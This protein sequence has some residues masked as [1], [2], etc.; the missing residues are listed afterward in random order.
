MHAAPALV[1]AAEQ[2]SSDRQANDHASQLPDQRL[3]HRLQQLESDMTKVRLCSSLQDISQMHCSSVTV[4][5]VQVQNML[6]LHSERLDHMGTDQRSCQQPL[7]VTPS[8]Q[9]AG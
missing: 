4:D 1:Q 7:V 8:R 2:G 6:L 3:V 9:P 5:V